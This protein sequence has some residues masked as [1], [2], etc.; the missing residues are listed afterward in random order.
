MGG[1]LPDQGQHTRAGPEL[2]STSP[3]YFKF[4]MKRNKQVTN[5]KNP[6]L[7][8]LLLLPSRHFHVE[9]KPRSHPFPRQERRYKAA[10]V[11]IPLYSPPKAPRE[12][13]E[14]R[15]T[16]TTASFLLVPTSLPGRSTSLTGKSTSEKLFSYHSLKNM[17]R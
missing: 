17:W 2:L 1:T 8:L 12:G 10:A 4:T 5:P 15:P 7:S 14:H 3:S 11:R 16:R 13:A 9:K 6:T